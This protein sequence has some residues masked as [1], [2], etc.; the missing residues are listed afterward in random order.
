MLSTS[1]SFEKTPTRQRRAQRESRLRS[2]ARQRGKQAKLA[3]A[4]S[5]V[6]TTLE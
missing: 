6:S 3:Q 1:A 4:L 5:R 2:T